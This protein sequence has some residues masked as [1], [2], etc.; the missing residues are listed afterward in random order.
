[1][2][3][4]NADLEPER[5]SDQHLMAEYRELPMVLAS[6]RRSL[7]TQSIETVVAKI[8]KRFTLGKGHVTF[9]YNKLFFLMGRYSTLRRELQIRGFALDPN[10]KVDFDGFIG[11]PLYNDWKATAKDRTLIRDR[12]RDRL[13]KRP[14]WYRYFGRIDTTR[15][16]FGRLVSR[17]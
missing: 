16:H 14:D 13:A 2:T 7:R 11:L 9:F 12:I 10:R 8:P 5:L 4:I 17:R 3:R 15:G 1:M 6:L